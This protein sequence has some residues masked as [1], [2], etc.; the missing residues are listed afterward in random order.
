MDA[1]FLT[2]GIFTGT[3]IYLTLILAIMGANIFLSVSRR[4]TPV[5]KGLHSLSFFLTVFLICR[6]MAHVILDLAFEKYYVQVS[7][8]ALI[9]V[10][11]SIFVTIFHLISLGKFS[12]TFMQLPD[13]RHITDGDMDLLL[14]CDCN[15][16]I[17]DKRIPHW[18]PYKEIHRIHLIDE[19]STLFKK[20]LDDNSYREITSFLAPEQTRK[21]M[22]LHM[23]ASSICLMWTL[24]PIEAKKNHELGYI[25]LIRDISQEQALRDEIE[26]SVIYLTQANRQLNDYVMVADQLEAEKEKLRLILEVQKALIQQISDVAK[27]AENSLELGCASGQIEEIALRLRNVMQIVRD[28][29]RSIAIPEEKSNENYFSR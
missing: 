29:V 1:R 6:F 14:I 15:R 20:E 2:W 26:D 10:A 23:P 12:G 5:L 9:G 19:M 7:R 18:F 16:K 27:F 17:I 21:Q 24:S 25:L 11:I 8:I 22:I 4:H 28:A 13:L 3:L